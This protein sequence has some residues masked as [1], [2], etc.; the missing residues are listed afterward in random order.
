MA[1]RSQKRRADWRLFVLCAVIL[2]PLL[3]A[4]TNNIGGEG[5]GWNPPVSKDGVLYVGT[6]EGSVKAYIDD[7]SGSLQESWTFRPANQ[8]AD[9]RGVHSTPI[10]VGDFVYVSAQDGF[11]YAIDK[12]TGTIGGTGWLRP[13]GVFEEPDSLIAG[14]TY[15]SVNDLILAPSEDGNIYAYTAKSG[16]QVWDPFSTGAAIWST[17]AAD[18][19]IGF[20]GSHDYKVYAITLN[21]GKELWHYE[22]GGVVAGKPLVFD[23]KVIAGSFDRKLYAFSRESG[24][25]EWTFEAD[26]WF[27]AGAVTD[28]NTIFAPNMDGNIYALDRN[29]TL[30]WKHDVGSAIVSPPVL[31]PQGLVVAAKDGFLL[32]LDTGPAGLGSQRVVF[33]QK[34]G[35]AEIKA[36]LFAVGSSVFVGSQDSTVRRIEFES[37]QRN[38]WCLHTQ[39]GN[40]N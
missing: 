11:L 36:P 8:V 14:P 34:I 9:T 6:K 29:G 19:G 20:F 10:V 1:Y 39:D 17:V 12:E 5:S 38:V 23:G 31:V 30:L 2:L 24:T 35:D 15:D 27:W 40:C 33:N 21:D 18:D 37:G 16:D 26:N 25:V 22:T 3:A 28:G 13:Q 7:G 32:L 4:C